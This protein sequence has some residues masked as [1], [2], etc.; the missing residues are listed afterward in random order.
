MSSVNNINIKTD[1]TVQIFD[2]F[3]GYQQ[4]VAPDEYDA[5]YSYFKLVFGNKLT[6]EAAGNF[7]VTLF[8]IANETN[9]SVMTL[10][11][12]FQGKSLPQITATMAYFLNGTRSASTLVG[13]NVQTQPNYYVAHNIR[14]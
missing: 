1:Q 10:L 13:V 6:S 2:R 7:T 12:Q 3:Y 4:S 11:Q 8:R 14:I 5:V 9:T